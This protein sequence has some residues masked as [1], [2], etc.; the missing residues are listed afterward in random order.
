MK[1][2]E[3]I[4]IGPTVSAYLSAWRNFVFTKNGPFIPGGVIGGY[5]PIKQ[6]GASHTGFFQ[7]HMSIEYASS[8][9][10]GSNIY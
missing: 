4:G 2:S 1:S 3:R 5:E 6:L 8:K 10:A 9:S 7:G